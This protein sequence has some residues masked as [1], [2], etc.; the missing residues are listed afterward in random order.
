MFL[1]SFFALCLAL[2]SAHA[3]QHP[4]APPPL[5][6]DV[7]ARLGNGEVVVLIDPVDDSRAIGLAWSRA[8]PGAVIEEVLDVKARVA[9]VPAT[10][11]VH[12]YL[13][14]PTMLGTKVENRVLRVRST[15]HILYTIDRDAHWVRFALDTSRANDI[16]DAQGSYHAVPHGTGTLLIYRTFA[17]LGRPVPSFVKQRMTTSN[18]EQQLVG[19]QARADKRAVAER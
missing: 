13:Q 8:S 2:A 6:A 12:Y 16:P 18:M 4:P 14:S 3:Q 19:I 11:S 5:R 1:P 15:F 7:L 9:E 17:D 10:H